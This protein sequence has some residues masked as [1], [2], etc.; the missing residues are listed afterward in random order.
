MTERTLQTKIKKI[1]ELEMQQKNLEKQI[2][3]L[4]ADIQEEMKDREQLQAGAYLIRWTRVVSNKFDSKAFQSEHSRL[5]K[6]YVKE[7]E[8]R[9]FAIAES[10]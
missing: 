9:R 6:K 2:S 7:V 10:K 5:Y 4:K 3:S 8:S 1:K